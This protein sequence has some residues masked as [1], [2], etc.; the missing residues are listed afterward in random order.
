[1]RT[2][3][4][5]Q[6]FVGPSGWS[7]KSWVQTTNVGLPARDRLPVIARLFNAV[8]V[9]GSFYRQ[10]R[11]ETYA[12]WR[13]QTPDEF[14]FTAK[15]HRYLTHYKRLSGVDESISRMRQQMG[16]LG[17]KLAAVLWQLPSA[18][19][20]D[21]ARLDDFLRALRA[22]PETRHALELRHRSWFNDEVRDRL[23]AARVAACISDAPDFPRWDV[24]TTDLV[25]VRLHGHTRK[26]ASS[27]A[28]ASL[29]RWAQQI[30]GWAAEGRDVHV[31]FDND[32]D[33]AAVRNGLELTR[34]LDL[35]A[36]GAIP[37]RGLPA[38]RAGH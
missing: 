5:G 36:P 7:Y 37:D 33:G 20:I 6:V 30:R 29:R 26:Y 25:Y 21:L 35:T 28:A 22:W 9:N 19:T 3:R 32:K 15:G 27:Y 18:F 31:Y 11:R 12:G 16:G 17:E 1:M 24:T 4:R 8:E 34:L 13:D 14:R 2:P 10:I 23:S 38:I